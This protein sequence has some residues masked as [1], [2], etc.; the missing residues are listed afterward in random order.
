MPGYYTKLSISGYG[1]CF[2][3]G[4]QKLLIVVKYIFNLYY[5]HNT[6]QNIKHTFTL[7]CLLNNV[8]CGL[9]ICYLKINAGTI[10]LMSSLV[11]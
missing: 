8:S 10:F 2:F 7:L 4:F 9:L 6:I 1:M 11:F 5:I 3:N